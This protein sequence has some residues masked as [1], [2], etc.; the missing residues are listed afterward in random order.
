MNKN[1]FNIITSGETAT[2]LIY[3]D[4]GDGYFSDVGSGVVARE[5]KEAE[6]SYKKIEVRINSMGGDVYAGIAIFN[7]FRN[8]KADIKIFVDGIAASMASVIALC[9]KPVEMSKYARLMIHSVSGGCYGT[10]K[11]LKDVIEQIEALEGTLADMYAEKT[12]MTAKKIKS[13]YFDGGDHYLTADEALS[14][15][16]IDGIYDADPV[17]EE[18]TPEQIYQL[19]NNRL[20]KPLNENQMNIE[21]LRKRPLF[22]DAATDA[23][24]MRIIGNLE[25]EAG[26]VPGLTNDVTRLNGELKV[27]Q[28]KAKADEDAAK[29]KLLDDAEADERINAQTRPVY[30]ALLDKDRENGEAAL[31]ALTPKKRAVTTLNKSGEPLNGAWE[32]RQ[33][34]IR[35]QYKN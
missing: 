1:F 10:K 25:T 14:L 28:V 27:F 35:N 19:F 16:F 26:K 23:D 21:D 18:S 31:K 13:S 6:T 9:G 8:S 5:L 17:P 15:G 3:G 33:E 34:E 11:D 20:Q 29:K 24:V 4:I 12:G 30:Q 2:I 32:K 22:K 7:A